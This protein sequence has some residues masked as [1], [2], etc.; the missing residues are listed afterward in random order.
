MSLSKTMMAARDHAL[1]YG[2]GQLCRLPG[3]YWQVPG[4]APREDR[5]FGTKTIEAMV[6]R[7]AAQYTEWKDSRHGRF[8][9][10]VS[11]TQPEAS[12]QG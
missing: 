2:G 7:G 8:P 12:Q 9:V 3:G 6:A 11:M 5:S 10:R 1:S 4:T